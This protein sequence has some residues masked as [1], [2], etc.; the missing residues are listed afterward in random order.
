MSD[1]KFLQIQQDVCKKPEAPEEPDRICATCIPN[2]AYI[3]PTWWEEKDP[4]LN[5]KTCEYS[6]AVTVNEDGR[7]YTLTDLQKAFDTLRELLDNPDIQD[8][9]PINESIIANNPNG[10]EQGAFEFIKRSF[11]RPA[12]RKMLRYYDKMEDDTI[13]C[14]SIDVEQNETPLSALA[15]GTFLLGMAA[16]PLA[17][18]GPPTLL[19]L[20]A[21]AGTAALIDIF[22]NSTTKDKCT[23]EEII[24]K[25][26]G[27]AI[28][29]AVNDLVQEV[30]LVFGAEQVAACSNITNLDLSEFINVRSQLTSFHS[31]T[32]YKTYDIEQ[33]VKEKFCEIKNLNAVEL[34]ARVADYHFHGLANNVMSVLVT[35]PAHIFDQIP[36]A[37]SLGEPN[38]SAESV[39]IKIAEFTTFISEITNTMSVFS[40]FQS[41]FY[42]NEGGRLFQ[43]IVTP[44]VADDAFDSETPAVTETTEETTGQQVSEIPFYIEGLVDKFELFESELSSFIDSK[45]YGYPGGDVLSQMRGFFGLDNDV[46]EIE[47]FFDKTDESRPF[48]LTDT[49]K[50]KT[51]GCDWIEL[52]LPPEPEL[53]LGEFST[54]IRSFAYRYQTVMGYIANYADIRTQITA[55]KTPPWLDFTV[56]NTFPQLVVNYG[57]SQMF[58]DK[59]AVNCLAEKT[60]QDLD[61]A[62]LNQSLSFIESFQY[63]MNKN[64]CKIMKNLYNDDPIIFDGNKETKKI[65]KMKKEQTKKKLNQQDGLL[66]S[67][68]EKKK[69]SKGGKTDEKTFKKFM[70]SLNPCNWKKVTMKAINC[71][72]AEMTIEEGYNTI[73]KSTLGNLS[74]AG[75]EMVL[76]GLPIDKQLAIKTEVQKQFKDMPAPWETGWESGDL[77]EAVD[78]QVM[79]KL[80]ERKQT[81]DSTLQSYADIYTRI[82]TIELRLEELNSLDAEKEALKILT[83]PPN[84]LTTKGKVAKQKLNWLN[85]DSNYDLEFLKAQDSDFVKEYSTSGMFGKDFIVG[86]GLGIDG[87]ENQPYTRQ[88]AVN[89]MNAI[90]QQTTN[91]ESFLRSSTEDL[92]A[93]YNRQSTITTAMEAMSYPCTKTVW[94]PFGDVEYMD[95][96][97]ENPGGE[98]Q[99]EAAF[100]K[101]GSNIVEIREAI[102]SFK[103]ALEANETKYKKA[104]QYSYLAE[105]LA[106]MLLNEISLE[107]QIMSDYGFSP[108]S[109]G[110][111]YTPDL[112]MLQR[113]IEVDTATSIGTLTKEL[114]A[115]R[116]K[117]KETEQEYGEKKEK[118]PDATQLLFWEGLSEEDK[119]KVIQRE[120]DKQTFISLNEDD[121]VKQGTLGRALGGVQKAVFDAYVDEIMKSADVTEL[122]NEINKLPGAA[123]IGDFIASFDCPRESMIYPPIDSFLNTLTTDPCGPGKTRIALPEIKRFPQRWNPFAGLGDAFVYAFK[124]TLAS[125]W[126]SLMLKQA[127]ILE[128]SACRSIEAGKRVVLNYVESG[129]TGLNSIIDDLVCKE[130]APEDKNQATMNLFNAVGVPQQNPASA[131]QL[132]D[133]MST[134]GTEDDFKKAMIASPDEQ[135]TVFLNNLARTISAVHP[136]Y[137]QFLGTADLMRDFLTKAGGFLTDD[138]KNDIL[139]LESP[140][141]NF[142]LETS[143]CL[144]KEEAE[145]YN[146][147]LKDFYCNFV[148]CEIADEFINK[149]KAKRKSD[150]SELVDALVK[151]PEDIFQDTINRVLAPPDPDCPVNQSIVT[152]PEPVQQMKNSMVANIFVGLKKAFLDDTIEENFLENAF[153]FD[154]VGVLLTILGDSVGYNLA[155][156]NRIRTNFIFKALAWIGIFDAKAPFP[157]TVGR[158]MREYI[159][160]E[161]TD[162]D[163]TYNDGLVRWHFHDGWDRGGFRTNQKLNEKYNLLTPSGDTIRHN[164]FNYT[165]HQYTPDF[166]ISDHDGQEIIIER[167]VS[168]EERLFLQKYEPSQEELIYVEGGNNTYKNLIF[169]NILNEQLPTETGYQFDLDFVNS[170]VNDLNLMFFRDFKKAILSDENGGVPQGFQH[171]GNNGLITLEDLTYVNP[172]EGSTAYTFNEEDRILGR[173]L[174]N[175]PRVKFL[176]PDK[177]GGS[178]VTPNIYIDPIE[179]TGWMRMS[180]MI[181]PNIAG[182]DPLSSNFLRLEE[183]EKFIGERESSIE[184]KEELSKSPDCF[185]EVPFDKVAAPGTLATLEAVVYATIRVFL[186]EFILFSMPIHSAIR[187]GEDNYDELIPEYVVSKM[188]DSMSKEG[189]WFVSTYEKYTYWLL[190]LEQVV[191]AYDRKVKLGEIKPDAIAEEILETIKSAQIN[192]EQ[193]SFETINNIRYGPQEEKFGIN[194]KSVMLIAPINTVDDFVSQ[195]EPEFGTTGAEMMAG[196]YIIGSNS[197]NWA[198]QLNDDIRKGSESGMPFSITGINALFMTLS[199]AR[200]ACKVTTIMRVEEHCKRLLNRLVKDQIKF[201]GDIIKKEMSPRPLAFDVFKYFLGASKTTLGTTCRAGLY[202]IEVPIGEGNQPRTLSIEEYGT[203]NHCSR[204]G[205]EH[206]LHKWYQ[207]TDKPLINT[208]PP[209][210]EDFSHETEQLINL[211]RNGGFF[212]EKYLRVIDKS[213]DIADQIRDQERSEARNPLLNEDLRDVEP[214]RYSDYEVPSWVNESRSSNHRDVVNIR[215][216]QNW[217]N[218]HKDLLDPFAN[219]SDYFGDAYQTKKDKDLNRYSGSTGIKFGVRLCYI[220]PPNAADLLFNFSDLTNEQKQSLRELNQKEKSYFFLEGIAGREDDS[221]APTFDSEGAQIYESGAQEAGGFYSHTKYVIP[222]VS[223]EQD[224]NDVKI[225]SLLDTDDNFGEDLK[226]YIDKLVEDPKFKI[227]FDKIL[228]VKKIPSYM[229][230]YSAANFYAS[231]GLYKAFEEQP[232]SERRSEDLGWLIEWLDADPPASPD[233]EDRGNTFNDC[234]VEARKIFTSV[235]KR[236][237]F[238]PPNEDSSFNLSLI[239]QKLMAQTYN[240]LQLDET[241]PWWYRK[242]VVNNRTNPTDKDGK[243]CKNQFAKLFDSSE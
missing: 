167:P 39:K 206:P 228:N 77:G 116:I 136:E 135:D 217:L 65:E 62:I 67:M 97:F 165:F 154:S 241:I 203:I 53:D 111:G 212:L 232:D 128:A 69:K 238:D 38:T 117:A 160:D 124:K 193:P 200:L 115:L 131:R 214:P 3:E 93:A 123:I 110:K 155:T 161:L 55:K 6:I 222:M 99:F 78:R 59:S 91:I 51:K 205:D 181:V 73:I 12:L 48:K 143:I 64:N 22:D 207:S 61:D 152:I 120:K 26:L 101:E 194:P 23:D 66:K 192:Y 45:G 229:A 37:P 29:G 182:C 202:D 163:S 145:K 89:A 54:N 15:K 220:P 46:I 102:L 1:S 70:E 173:S 226:C 50:I 49:M 90:K 96:C 243:E 233:A 121:K 87:S 177:Y 30:G 240:M 198:K 239:I 14:A 19:W 17:T 112:D 11:K 164:D 168:E 187:L 150:L 196:S 139:N 113:K 134:L 7:S 27:E 186:S 236:N 57:T 8:F 174:T 9:H 4:W 132:V 105:E 16:A 40:K 223:Y 201:Y 237:D 20:G 13:L 230:C 209:L 47:L 162:D 127:Y 218:A 95:I 32:Q 210:F 199:M 35:I 24:D 179:A 56:A 234:K 159:L 85:G 80:G 5:E 74:G 172:Q 103:E 79:D 142:P 208:P 235:Y 25:G 213:S 176:N 108:D 146:A 166:T 169:R 76:E 219:I 188:E 42:Q 75:L 68:K 197:R 204:N 118:T 41:A 125:V 184:K 149:Q 158:Y 189:G 63:Q 43:Q 44:T 224:I 170:V 231:V 107:D 10:P 185:V 126:Q 104:E 225:I 60:L 211:R 130:A 114:D 82:T 58:S 137:A 151:G 156:H 72:L 175:N 195:L 21:T 94:T 71:L 84:D 242:R 183:L 122:L 109:T 227:I 81:L 190:F 119:N 34:Y 147:D 98:A 216:F 18:L 2:P 157:D 221:N 180:R 88:M 33:K 83:N 144:S 215:V 106:V 28:M 178:F 138:Q 52:K 140:T 133:T 36:Q 31:D 148:G 153:G 129:D 141:A 191:Q 92:L 86:L 171:G 100:Q